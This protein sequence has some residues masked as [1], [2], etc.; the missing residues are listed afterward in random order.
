VLVII[1]LIPF[2][3]KNLEQY[4]ILLVQVLYLVAEVAAGIHAP[5]AALWVLVEAVEEMV[6]LGQTDILTA[7]IQKLLAAGA[8]ADM[9]VMVV[10]VPAAVPQ[11]VLVMVEVAVEVAAAV[12]TMFTLTLWVVV[13]EVVAWVFMGKE[14]VVLAAK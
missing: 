1:I 9:Q 4:L 8:R 10:P 6:E 5:A 12:I 7:L 11:A 2:Q 14:Q 13:A 3:E